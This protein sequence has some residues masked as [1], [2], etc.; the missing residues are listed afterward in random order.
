MQIRPLYGLAEPLVTFPTDARPHR[1][2]VAD[3]DIYVLDIGRQAVI[4]FRY[5]PAVGRILDEDGQMVLRQGDIVDG[6]A[7]GTLADLA[8]L[9]LIPGVEDK[10]M[11]LVLDR[12]N[13][14]FSYDRRVEGARRIE[15]TDQAE[16][17]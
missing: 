6:V 15:M 12:N 17:R 11:L 14:L 1:V 8:W 4:R 5:D 13:N 9:P 16:W 2:L 3:D 7:V 10:A